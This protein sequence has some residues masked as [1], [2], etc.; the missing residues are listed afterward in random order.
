[1]ALSYEVHA[2]SEWFP[3]DLYDNPEGKDADDSTKAVMVQMGV[4]KFKTRKI[5]EDVARKLN[6]ALIKGHVE[7]TERLGL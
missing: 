2:R 7:A 4:L 6:E 5:S 3:I 1:M